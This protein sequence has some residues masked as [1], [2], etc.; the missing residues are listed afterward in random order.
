MEKIAE[1][2]K[3]IIDKSGNIVVLSGLNV[4]R[5]TGLNG[6]RAEHLAYETEEKYGY[7]NDEIISSA[8]YARRSEIFYDY[9]KNVTINKE[10]AEPTIVHKAI[11]QLQQK[12]KVPHI[13]SRTVYELYENAGCKH[14]LDIHGSI[15]K[16]KCPS[17]G[18]IFDMKYIKDS[19]GEPVCDTC[20]VP[21]RPG[22]LL[23][24]E[25][26]DNGKISEACDAIEAA[27]VLLVLGSGVMDPLC[28]HL[29]KYYKGH[30]FILVNTEEK[31]G[32]ERADYRIYGKISE[33][34]PYI[35]G[36][37]PDAVFEDPDEESEA[38]AALEK[39]PAENS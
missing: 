22:F 18:K 25:R 34:V 28:Q 8:F 31:L 30:K 16:N 37:D 35:T 1:G 24:G 33:I 3:E 19:K 26:V 11:R 14:V 10:T 2:I 13:I 12:G 21:I 39:E 15:Q 32:D 38:A 4:M 9:I 36:Y 17:C 20:K 27:D 23:L 5:E 7:A 29:Q 6:V